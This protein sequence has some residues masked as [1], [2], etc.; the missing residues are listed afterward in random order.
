MS[1]TPSEAQT[2]ISIKRLL[3]EAGWR[4]VHDGRRRPANIVYEQRVR[5]GRLD[6]G[7]DL[8][9]DFERAPEFRGRSTNASHFLF[10]IER[11]SMGGQRDAG[12]LLISDSHPIS[13]R[14]VEG[15][16]ELTPR[17]REHHPR[18]DC[19]QRPEP[20][21][22]APDAGRPRRRFGCAVNTAIILSGTGRSARKTT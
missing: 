20:T 18:S 22:F 13:D 12:T 14:R 2:R 11:E 1:S 10:Q 7:D 21:P 17:L 15:A 3:E 8:G 19:S 9:K 6:P 16:G 5:G 4:F